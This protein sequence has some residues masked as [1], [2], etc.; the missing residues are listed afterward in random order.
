ME[1][2]A[3][4]P[5]PAEAKTWDHILTAVFY[6]TSYETVKQISSE[7]GDHPEAVPIIIDESAN[8]GRSGTYYEM[9]LRYYEMKSKAARKEQKAKDSQSD[10]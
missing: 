9:D 7:S 4:N 5:L 6:P 2:R 3:S 1:G 8:P 10:D